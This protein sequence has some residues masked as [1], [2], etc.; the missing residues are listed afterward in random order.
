MA[1]RKSGIKQ[2]RAQSDVTD[3]PAR[4]QLRGG[5]KQQRAPSRAN[6][7]RGS[8]DPEP[9][10]NDDP[11]KEFGD[12]VSRMYLTNKLSAKNTKLLAS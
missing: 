12:H 5:I 9:A 6:A 1:S 7:P 4:K 3:E 2:E 11:A 8:R 10:E